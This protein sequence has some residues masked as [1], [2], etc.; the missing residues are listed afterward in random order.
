[1]Q[2]ILITGGAGTVGSILA[3][4]Y[5]MRN[6][7]VVVLDIDKMYI[8]RLKGQVGENQNIKYFCDSIM[9]TDILFELCQ[10]VDFVIHC[11]ANKY[12]NLCEEQPIEAYNVNTLGAVNVAKISL[13]CKAKKVIFVSSDKAV[14]PINTYGITKALMEKVVLSLSNSRTE[15]L[16]TRMGNLI[17]SN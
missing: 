17:G 13:G 12:V 4:Y 10:N 7:Q 16:C 2:K 6:F 3:K 14:E 1:M 9:N 11:A 5:L 15:I 8:E